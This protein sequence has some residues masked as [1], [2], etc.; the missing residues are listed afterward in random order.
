MNLPSKYSLCHYF[1]IPRK[2]DQDFDPLSSIPEMHMDIDSMGSPITRHVYGRQKSQ[3]SAS[4]S[5]FSSFFSGFRSKGSKKNVNADA[6]PYPARRPKRE[7]NS[8]T[9]CVLFI[10]YK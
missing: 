5:K 8:Y 3:G 2:P 6:D 4:G 7:Y 1:S 9:I 10:Y